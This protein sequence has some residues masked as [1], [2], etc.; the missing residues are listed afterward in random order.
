MDYDLLDDWL[1]TGLLTSSGNKWK[2]R[3][4]IITP[5]FHDHNLLS[6][7][8][9]TFN[10]QLEVCVKRLNDVADRAVET[11]VYRLISDWTL[12]VICG[13]STFVN[14]DVML[15]VALPLPETAMAKSIGVQVKESDY[16]NAVLR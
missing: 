7:C 1:G 12:D 16:G 2:A 6:N 14:G 8:I 4:R 13:K 11:N 10:G 5:S 9:D 3:R 15:T